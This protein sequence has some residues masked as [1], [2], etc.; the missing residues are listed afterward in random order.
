MR[1]LMLVLLCT[2]ISP[3]ALEKLLA[4]QSNVLSGNIKSSQNKEN[5]P[6]VS[7]M[8]KGTGIGTFSDDKG[9]FKLVTTQNPPF[10]IVVSSIGYTSKEVNVENISQP[11]NIEIEASYALGQEIVVAASRI[12]ERILESPVS[13]ERVSAKDVLQSPAS[14]YYDVVQNL[15]G[16]DVV[17]ASLTFK[18]ISTRG[19]NSSGNVRLNQ[20]VDGMDNQAPGLNFSVGNVVGLTD[21]DVDNME[22][23]EGASSALYGPGGMNGTFLINSKSPFK[24]QGVSIQVREGIMNVDEKYRSTSPYHDFSFRWGQKVSD[25]FAFKIGAQYVWAKDWLAADSSN[26]YADANIYDS[27]VIPGTRT[28]DQNYNGVNVY[29]DETSLDIT[30]PNTP[31]LMGVIGTITDPVAQHYALLATA[32]F[33]AGPLP[34]SRTGYNEADVVPPNTINFK[35]SGGLYYKLN[36]NLEA[37]LTGNW[38]TGNTVYTGSDRYVFK[39]LKIGQYKLEFRSKN[40]FLRA[41]TTQENSGESYN[42]TVTSRLFNE[43]WKPS[44]NPANSAGSWYPQYSGALVQGATNVYLGVIMAGGTPE[45]AQAAVVANQTALLN[46]AR[47]YADANRPVP[48]SAAFNRIFDSVRL[49]PIPDGGKF[50]DRSDLYMVEGQY[51]LTDALHIGAENKRLEVLV[52][53]NYKLYVLDSK[54]TVFADTVGN[55]IEINEWGGYVQ[56]SRKFFNDVLKLTASGRYDKNEN[57]KDRFTPRVSAVVTVAKNHNLRLSYQTAYRFPTTQN[58]WIDLTIGGGVRL[59]GG[60]PELK[61]KYHFDTNPVYTEESFGK[62]AQSHNPADLVVQQFNEYKPES[63]N[64]FE[65]GY[66]GLINNRLLID[67]YGYWATYENFLG[68]I[69]VL[70]SSD[71]TPLGLATP[72]IYS[73]SVNSTSKVNANGWGVSLQYLLPRGFFINA[74]VFSDV[75]TNVPENFI[76]YFNAPKYRYNLGFG[77][78]GIDKQKRLGFNITYRWQ[79]AFFYESDF[80]QGNLPAFGTLDAQV[81]YKLPKQKLLFKLGGTNITNHY[82]R[83]GFGNPYIGGLYYASIAYNVF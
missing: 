83:N 41:Y 32:P 37:S 39:D 38:G 5:L 27:K 76:T 70:Q 28:T 19:F 10:T 44:Y 57:F 12:P 7:V 25:K 50:L 72:T 20:L 49:L 30:S 34:V 1:K 36:Q 78:S 26:Y 6:A 52:G 45:E 13:I 11:L 67:A 8:I 63:S 66:K 24:Y 59:I 9:N 65:V 55:P 43:A 61:K 60:L 14:S 35:L 48:G 56:L 16:V 82:Y 33:L 73:V 74:N 62:F 69:V 51:N 47:A 77:N 31:F 46:G 18:S 2:T 53:A 58:Q 29:G 42:A 3:F 22:L 80:R 75:L 4:Q 64:S 54:G 17:T 81:S 71:G 23:L 68:R 79:D 40:W 15:K 21:L